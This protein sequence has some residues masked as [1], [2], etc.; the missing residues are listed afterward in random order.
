MMDFE[1]RCDAGAGLWHIHVPEL[2]YRSPTYYPDGH[3]DQ[4]DIVMSFDWS[5]V[6]R[7]LLKQDEKIADAVR[8]A[9]RRAGVAPSII[10]E[11]TKLVGERE[12]PGPQALPLAA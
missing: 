9:L 4:F 12:M 11:V 3:P 5:E 8:A 7:A 2:G 1:C 10:A 6:C